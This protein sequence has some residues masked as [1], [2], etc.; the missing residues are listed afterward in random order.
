MKPAAPVTS[1]RTPLAPSPRR[2]ARSHALR[3]LLPDSKRI[4][5]AAEIGGTLRVLGVGAVPGTEHIDGLF[6]APLQPE[7]AEQC[8]KP[9]EILLIQRCRAPELGDPLIDPPGLVV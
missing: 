1:A 7:G 9:V 6:A 8:T 5:V 4:L 3:P 2:R